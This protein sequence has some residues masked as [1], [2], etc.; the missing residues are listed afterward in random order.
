MSC[1]QINRVSTRSRIA[2]PTSIARS[3]RDR[4]SVRRSGFTLLELLLVL[5]ILVVIGGIVGT[6]ILG[7]KSD[8]DINATQAQ[9]NS[10]K[11]NI[12]YYKLKT[13]SLPEALEQ[14]RDG[15]SDAAKKAQWVDSI[16]ESVPVDAWGNEF[17]FSTKGNQFE[18]RSAGLDG[19]MNTE[20]DIVVEGR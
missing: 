6:N 20:D 16:I 3:N 2:R 10:L 17:D 19:Q 7:A 5:A 13:N 14:L 9:L 1:R 11:S 15:P 18:I 8:A 12:V 4:R